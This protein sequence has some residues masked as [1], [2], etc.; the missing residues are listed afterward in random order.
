[1]T[2]LIAIKAGKK[3]VVK[4][5]EEAIKLQNRGWKIEIVK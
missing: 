5:W 1:M 3:K 2:K 4:S